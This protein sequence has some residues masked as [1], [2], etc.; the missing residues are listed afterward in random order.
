MAMVKEL[1]KAIKDT[2][3]LQSHS[4]DQKHACY[5]NWFDNMQLEIS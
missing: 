2:Q 5:N 3:S 1:S 4:E